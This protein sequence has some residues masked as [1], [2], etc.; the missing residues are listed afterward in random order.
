MAYPSIAAIAELTRL[1]SGDAMLLG[2]GPADSTVL[3]GIE[4]KSIY[5][6]I[7]SINT[8]RLQAT[9]LPA[10]IAAYDVRWLLYY[11]THRAGRDG[12]LE[13]GK[14]HNWRRHRL[15]SRSVPYGY[16]HALLFDLAAVGMSVACVASE[17][18]A[19]AW[20]ACL[21]RWWTKPWSAHRGL[22]TFDNSRNLS[23]MPGMDDATWMRA[24]IAAQL[25]GIGF[26]RAVAVAAHFSTVGAMLTAT[27]SEWARVPGIGKVIAKAVVN[28][29]R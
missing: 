9:Q 29:L 4:V 14:G 16:L 24:R 27:E 13:I 3:V 28:E 22:H 11:G 5:D 8:G 25:P 10:M 12:A 26:E 1:E 15:G 20:L 23:L 21:Y 19:A 17:A 18:D 7:A 6:L 2:H